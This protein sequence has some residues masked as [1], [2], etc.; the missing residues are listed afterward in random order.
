MKLRNLILPLVLFVILGA[1]A[2][3]AEKPPIEVRAGTQGT[4][5]VPNVSITSIVDAVTIQDVR[6][7]RGN[8]KTPEYPKLPLTLKFG[9]TATF[10]GYPPPREVE[11]Q[12]NMGKWTFTFQ[13]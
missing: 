10:A 6:I 12:T 2:C 8:T 7:N 11:V 13:Q 9:E 1:N 3:N 5:R 4:A